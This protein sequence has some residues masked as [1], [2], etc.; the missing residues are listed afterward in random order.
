M[1]RR[2]LLLSLLSLPFIVV[3]PKIQRPKIQH[4]TYGVGFTTPY[5]TDNQSWYMSS[6]PKFI[7]AVNRAVE[8][9]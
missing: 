5:L 3:L 7:A 4:Q 1:N 2:S 9:S 6:D 8:G